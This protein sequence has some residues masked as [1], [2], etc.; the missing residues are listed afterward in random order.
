MGSERFGQPLPEIV[1][2]KQLEWALRHA[3]Q[4]AWRRK[5]ERASVFFPYF[6]LRMRFDD[7]NARAA[8]EAFGVRADPLRS[9][10]DRLM[11][12]AE[13]AAWGARPVSRL[14]AA[15]EH[16]VVAA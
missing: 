2:H 1:D 8:L 7:R 3:P 10:F 5:L 6:R 12:Y 15:F 9:Y 11:D 16:Q 13:R 4:G 14:D